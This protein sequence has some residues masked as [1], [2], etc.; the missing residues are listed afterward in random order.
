[1]SFASFTAG[2][3]M[4]SGEHVGWS[5]GHPNA[6]RCVVATGLYLALVGLM[7]GAIGLIVRHTAGAITTLLGVLF[8]LPALSQVL[9]DSVRPQVTRFFPESIGE[10]SATG[11]QITTAHFSPWVGIALMTGYVAVLIATGC[12]LLQRRDS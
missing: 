6:L 1:L 2:Q 8:V 3:A 12:F 5:L 7:A 11:Y 9:P 10:Q 4:L